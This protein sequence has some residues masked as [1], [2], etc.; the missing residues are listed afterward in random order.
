MRF[1]WLNGTKALFNLYY[2]NYMKEKKLKRIEVILVFQK[3]KN[4]V[5][6]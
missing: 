2:A 5:K 4:E 1:Y 6:L 3:K